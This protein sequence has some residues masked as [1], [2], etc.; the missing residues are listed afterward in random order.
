M[1]NEMLRN[2]SASDDASGILPL[3]LPGGALD[4]R[5]RRVADHLRLVEDRLEFLQPGAGDDAW[6]FDGKAEL[7]KASYVADIHLLR[8]DVPCFLRHWMINYAF[9]VEPD[10]SFPEWTKSAKVTSW[11][12]AKRPKSDLMNTAWFMK[13]FRNLLVM[14]QDHTLWLARAT[15]R[16]WLEQGKKIGVQ[17]APTYFGT[18][19]YEI[20]SDVDNGKINATVELH[21]ARRRR[22]SSCASVILSPRRSRVSPSTARIGRR[23]T[24]T[25]KR[26]N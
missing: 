21:R 9:Y 23:S 19:A 11:E 13:N 12:S 7:V 26:S 20:V 16:A 24:R 2:Y 5:D 17:N 4:P 10:G 22:R 8:D 3:A 6:F 25:R 1:I 18:V 15:P 14:E